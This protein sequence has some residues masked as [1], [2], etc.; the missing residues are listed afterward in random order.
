MSHDHNDNHGHSH[1][2]A[3]QNEIAAPVIFALVCA[4][5]AVLVIYILAK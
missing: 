2:E 1:H 3:E 5:I 4:A